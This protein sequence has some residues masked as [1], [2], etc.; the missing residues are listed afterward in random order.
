M[1][2]K[3]TYEEFN[4]W[5]GLAMLITAVVFVVS[6]ILICITGEDTDAL[7]SK[8]GWTLLLVDSCIILNTLAIGLILGCLQRMG[9]IK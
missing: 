3:M 9:V 6:I 4:F 1:K 8:I 5:S 7:A 2:K